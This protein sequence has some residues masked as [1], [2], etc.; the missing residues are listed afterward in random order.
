MPLSLRPFS[1]SRSG[2]Q[3]RCAELRL[4]AAVCRNWRTVG[5]F[6][7]S[8]KPHSESAIPEMLTPFIIIRSRP[9]GNSAAPL[10]PSPNPNLTRNRN[11]N[12]NPFPLFSPLNPCLYSFLRP[13]PLPPPLP[14]CPPPPSPLL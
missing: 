10:L 12:L 2:N 8:P 4:Q 6:F 14:F 3:T 11:L 13:R 7:R 1:V 9:S 5:S